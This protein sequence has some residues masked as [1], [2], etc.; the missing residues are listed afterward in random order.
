MILT[1]IMIFILLIPLLNLKDCNFTCVIN[2]NIITIK[3]VL[4]SS[5]ANK[6]L[7]SIQFTKTNI[8]IFY[9]L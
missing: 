6:N 2:N 9:H 7:T 4:Y 1:F 8:K 5:K 3:M